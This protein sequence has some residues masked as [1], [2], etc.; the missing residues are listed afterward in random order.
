M[1]GF[2]VDEGFEILV[3]QFDDLGMSSCVEPDLTLPVN[4]RAA[5]E[6]ITPKAETLT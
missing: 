5:P 4:K 1:S 6:A 3:C 2:R